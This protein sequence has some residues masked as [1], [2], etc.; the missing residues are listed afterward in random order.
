M[1]NK[2]HSLIFMLLL[3]L[4][5]MWMMYTSSENEA[6][7]QQQAEAKKM[8]EDS[9]AR[10]ADSIA[11]TELPVYSDTVALSDSARNVELQ[12]V[13]GAF[14]ASANGA[15]ETVSLENDLVKIDFSTVGGFVEKATLK[16]YNLYGSS[17]PVV[18]NK[19]ELS[20]F[21]VELESVSAK[22]ISTEEM[23]FAVTAKNDTSV[24]LSLRAAQGGSLD[25]IYT[26]PKDEYMMSFK[27]KADG[28]GNQLKSASEVTINWE[29]QIEQKE[30]GRTFENRY[31]QLY[32]K[33][34][35]G[36]IDYL[37]EVEDDEEKV[38][39]PV[40]WIGFKDQFFSSIFV[41]GKNNKFTSASL[42]SSVSKSKNKEVPMKQFKAEMKLPFD[43]N[44]GA[45]ADFY[46]YFGPNDYDI[47]Y[48]Y[49]DK[50]DDEVLL[51]R[52]VAIGGGILRWVNQGITIPLFNFF[53]S[54]LSN[55][56]LII[57]LVTLVIK[58]LIFPFTRSSYLSMAKMRVLKPQIEEINAR[59]PEDKGMERQQ[60][61]MQLYSR[62]GVNPMGGC[63]PML[64]QMPFLVAM[65]YFFP[66]V[67]D[68][69]GE[70]FLWAED[71]SSYDDVIKFG[72][73]IPL[74]GDH[75]S[76]F[77]LL[78]TITN[79]VYMY[80]NSKMQDTGATQQMPMMKIMMY[81]MPF[82]FFFMFNDY[83]SGLTYY[84]FVSLLIT[85][86]INFVV[87]ATVDEKKLLEKIKENQKK[88][89]NQSSW[90]ARM[91]EMQ[92]KQKEMMEAQQR[93][94]NKNQNKK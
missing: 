7:F 71:L 34:S 55:Y 27:M 85:I 25:F 80:F 18:L 67:I 42:S 92:Q 13:Y 20:R 21:N 41:N 88:P 75:L 86:I 17:E 1:E 10:N 36:G 60:E 24:T 31:V 69:R 26:L 59:I 35:D 43:A 47:L 22:N 73:E 5:L 12:K 2:N 54:F 29:Q 37:S 3:G 76:L 57:L 83:G 70:S 64:L 45:T 89:Q 38:E 94:Q 90:M 72:T 82:M 46:L 84:Y 49:D 65:Y 63:L 74:L 28:I 40:K 62:A 93:M 61:V 91:Q 77:C 19:S 87:K 56:G 52:I 33:E 78:M 4:S 58:M 79:V 16:K 44:K 50:L 51:N 32:Y 66:S 8:R 6:Y 11:K 23:C 9:L 48:D 39:E 14:A 30:K 68:L 15:N 53:S 81:V